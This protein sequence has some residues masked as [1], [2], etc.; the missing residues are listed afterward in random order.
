MEF[1]IERSAFTDAVAWAAR[2]L[3]ARSAVP[4]LG[5]LLLEAGEGRLRVLG[6]DHDAAA[7]VTAEAETGRSGRALV[8]GR[9]L[10]DICRVLPKGT[11][12]CAA[13]R[14]RLTV[15]CG[16]ASRRRTVAA[17]R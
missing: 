9:R 14:V 2:V 4:V 16:D 13:D 1:S 7:S 10:L 6:V 11:V 8:M 15:T 12:E 3:P 5:G 17:A